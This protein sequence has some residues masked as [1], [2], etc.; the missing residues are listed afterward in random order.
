VW[1][2]AQSLEIL[3]EITGEDEMSSIALLNGLYHRDKSEPV[4]K[5]RRLFV[6]LI[7]ILA[8][9]LIAEIVFHFVIS[10]RL[11]LTKVEVIADGELSLTDAAIVKLAGLEGD[12]TFFGV[13]SEEIAGRIASYAPV[14]SA[15]AEKVFPNTLRIRIAQRTP[16]ALCLA[17][18]DGR[19]VPIMVDEEGVVFQIGE[20]VQEYDLP[21]LSGFVFASVELGQRINRRLLGFFKE[22]QELKN[23]SPAVFGLVSELSFIKKD[24]AGFEV[25]LYP[26]DYRV[27]V[28]LVSKID[29]DIMRRILL[30]LDVFANQGMLNTIEEIDFRTDT[31]LVRFKEE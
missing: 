16:L 23:S 24:R 25:L 8:L 28:R 9:I 20:S 22:L 10:P 18:V 19:T 17:E 29:M 6:I 2:I 7:A 5:I 26:R 4:P 12:E 31:P 13:D 27:P 30:V 3:L 21:V 11:R 1:L 14:K 15:S